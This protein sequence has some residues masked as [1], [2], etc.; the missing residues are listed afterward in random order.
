M[1]LR[2]LLFSLGVI[3]SAC[4]SPSPGTTTQAD[5]SEP[6]SVIVAASDYTSSEV[7]TLALEGA[8]KFYSAGAVLG[9]DPALASSQGR[10]FWVDRLG[11]N[12]IEL[13]PSTGTA[14]SDTVWTTSDPDFTGSTDPQDVAV[15]PTTGDAWIARFLVSTVL[16]KTSDGSTDVAR[17]D[18]SGV[19][20]VNRNPYMSSIRIVL[21][22]TG[23]AK[24]YVAL[25]MLHPYPQ[26]ID[27]SYLVK[28]DVPSRAIESTL[29]LKGRNPFGLIVEEGGK[30]YL[31]APG[32]VNDVTETDAGIEVVDLATFTSTLLVRESDLGASVDEV[33]IA[34]GATCGTAIVMGAQPNVNPTSVISFNVATGAIVTPLSQGFLSTSGFDLAGMAWLSGGQNLVGDRRAVSGSGYAVHVLSASSS[35][36][37]SEGGAPLYAPL[38]PVAMVAIP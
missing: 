8:A 12:V 15:D 27:P 34:S 5:S 18:L 29:E 2:F 17:I 16:V 24:A 32:N 6:A 3:A 19:A 35:C 23:V 38:Q 25:E 20:G 33:S 30:L 31:A 37:L 21:D 14:L 9:V 4:S 36:E 13:N 28:I 22:A 1:V 10:V 26:S 11:G 7:G